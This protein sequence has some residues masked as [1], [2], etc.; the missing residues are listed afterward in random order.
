MGSFIVYPRGKLGSGLA[1]RIMPGSN[2]KLPVREETV[3][4]ISIEDPPNNS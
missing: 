3:P 4:L 1:S 2:E